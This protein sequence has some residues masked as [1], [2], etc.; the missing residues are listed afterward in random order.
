MPDPLQPLP[1]GTTR[2]FSVSMNLSLFY[3]FVSL[4]SSFTGQILIHSSV[5]GH[6]DCV[7]IL[8]P[9]QAWPLAW[10][11]VSPSC[12]CSGYT[13]V[14]GR[15]PVWDSLWRGTC[16]GQGHYPGSEGLGP[17]PPDQEPLCRGSGLF[18]MCDGTGTP[19]EVA[20]KPCRWQEA[21][22]QGSTSAGSTVLARLRESDKNW[23][24]PTLNLLVG[25]WN[26]AP[27]SISVSGRSS[28]RILPFRYPF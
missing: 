28:T 14:C 12:D 11:A 8:T 2:L 25:A 24:P 5:S 22:P 26:L 6:L 13:G 17:A 15:A 18:A 21:D 4:F 20:A 9:T 16:A 3:L 27:T 10:L 23:C 19:L 7:Y 1:L